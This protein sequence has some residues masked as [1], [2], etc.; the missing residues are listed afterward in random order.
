MNEDTSFFVKREQ[1][2]PLIGIFK[3]LDQLTGA[4]VIGA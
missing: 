3:G 1:A 4:R 2:S